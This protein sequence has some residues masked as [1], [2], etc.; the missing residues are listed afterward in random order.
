MEAKKQKLEECVLNLFLT[1]RIPEH[2]KN[3]L[4]KVINEENEDELLNR[5]TKKIKF[6]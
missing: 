5:E 4:L 6:F 3:I 1:K 2:I